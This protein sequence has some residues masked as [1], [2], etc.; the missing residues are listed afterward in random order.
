MRHVP[1]LM[2]K[3]GAD[4]VFAAALP[5]GRA[6][7][8]KIA[9][10]GDRAR[11]AGDGG[12]A[13]SI[14]HRHVRGRST[15]GGAHHGARSPGGHGAGDRAVSIPFVTLDDPRYGEAVQVAPLIRRVIA[16]NP[17]KFTY[18]GT[19]TYIVGAGDVAVID[20]GPI[21]DSHREALQTQRSRASG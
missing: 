19:G 4:G 17:S 14:G 20:P 13:A 16:K 9:D 7:A 18:H 11:P 6:I 21:S 5:D 12:G 15:G 8:L 3:D 10:G 1:G 2:A